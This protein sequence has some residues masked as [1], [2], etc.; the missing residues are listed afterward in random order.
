[1]S[2]QYKFFN[3]SAKHSETNEAEFN[4]FLKSNNITAINSKFVNMGENS[5]WSV[6]VQYKAESK[7]ESSN[8]KQTDKERTDYKQILKPNDFTLYLRLREWRKEIGEKEKIPLYTI[9]TNEQLSKIAEQ[10]TDTAEKLQKIHGVGDS[11]IKNYS[12][13]VI[14]IV[15]DF[16]K[17]YNKNNVIKAD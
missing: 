9:F 15:N 5:Y 1:L 6:N 13:A 17:E 10:R 8:V 14:R 4:K 11:K 3:I 16:N 2:T 7:S 12:K